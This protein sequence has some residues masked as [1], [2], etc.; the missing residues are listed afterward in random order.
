MVQALNRI[1][2]RDGANVNPTSSSS[3]YQLGVED[4]C[5]NRQEYFAE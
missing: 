3:D 2:L 5:Q 1:P 4:L